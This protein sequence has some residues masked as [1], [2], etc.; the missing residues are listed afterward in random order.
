MT[1]L[2]EAVQNYVKSSSYVPK[3]EKKPNEKSLK[4]SLP[5]TFLRGGINNLII[6]LGNSRKADLMRNKLP[7]LMLDNEFLKCK[8]QSAQIQYFSKNWGFFVNFWKNCFFLIYFSTLFF[9]NFILRSLFYFKEF[10][11]LFL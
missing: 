1:S 5:L 2:I 9:K 4:N 3:F 6:K 8:S 11:L 7:D 10:I